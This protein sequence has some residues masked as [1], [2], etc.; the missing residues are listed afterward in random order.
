M[1]PRKLNKKLMLNKKTISNLN[2]QKMNNVIGGKTYTGC[3]TECETCWTACW[4]ECECET[5]Q[6]PHCGT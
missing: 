4:T 1:K 6:M 2:A 5:W 3:Y